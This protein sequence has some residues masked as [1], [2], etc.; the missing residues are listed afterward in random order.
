MVVE[1]WGIPKVKDLHDL[2]RGYVPEKKKTNVALV[3]KCTGSTVGNLCF[4][5]WRFSSPA[6]L[7]FGGEIPPGLNG[8]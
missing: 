7:V 5:G 6:M 2:Q 8:V 1:V 3:G 4:K